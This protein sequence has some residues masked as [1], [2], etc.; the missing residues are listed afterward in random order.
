V[1]TRDHLTEAE[2]ERLIEATQDNRYGHRDATMVFV[3]Y[4]HSLRA[5]AEPLP[6]TATSWRRMAEQ[7]EA[8]DAAWRP[9]KARK[10]RLPSATV[11]TA[12]FALSLDVCA[13]CPE[14]SF[15]R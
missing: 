9:A 2:V 10:F 6:D 8:I 13:D 12:V 15:W 7:Q 14:R 3:A 4:R 11:L 5:A 1:R